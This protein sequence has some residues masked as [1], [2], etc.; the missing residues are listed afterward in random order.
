MFDQSERYCNLSGKHKL[1]Y[2]FCLYRRAAYTQEIFEGMIWIL[3]CKDVS[4]HI[5]SAHAH[6]VG[7]YT[8]S[9]ENVIFIIVFYFPLT[10]ERWRPME[11]GEDY[12]FWDPSSK[13]FSYNWRIGIFAKNGYICYDVARCL[14]YSS[15]L[16]CVFLSI[17]ELFK[18]DIKR[19][20]CG[21][22]QHLHMGIQCDMLRNVNSML[23]K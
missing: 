2:N 7:T 14:I 4:R 8:P 19:E 17:S 13:T 15:I 23:G 3:S 21:K 5:P 16:I 9:F 6:I 1:A 18:F 20:C 12:K 11:L 10:S 22:E